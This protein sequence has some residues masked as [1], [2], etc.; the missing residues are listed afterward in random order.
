MRFE[1]ISIKNYRQYRELTIEFPAVKETDLH[2]LVA[3]NGIGKTNLLNAINWCLYGDEPHLGNKEGSLSIC[4][5]ASMRENREAGLSSTEV[6]VC[7]TAKTI[8]SMLKIERSI[9]VNSATGF[10]GRDALKI[11]E[12]NASGETNICEGDEAQELI[13]KLLPQKIRQYFFFDGEQLFNYFGKGS[14]TTHVKDSIH[15]IAQV[16]IVI[17]ARQHLDNIIAEYQQQVGR[18]NPQLDQLT[19]KKEELLTNKAHYESLIS[20]LEK[21]ITKSEEDI[22]EMS[23]RI[24]GTESVV[25]DNRI[26]EQNLSRLREIE[27]EKEEAKKTLR[28]LIK[29]YYVL[30]ALHD[31][32][33][34]TDAYITQKYQ[35]GSLPP[36]IDSS[37]IQ[38]SLEAHKCELCSAPLSS[39]SEAY[40]RSLLE[41][42]NISSVV[43]NK[44]MQIKNDVSRF[45]SGTNKYQEDLRATYTLI[46][47]LEDE[48]STLEAENAELY[49][50]ISAC[51]SSEQIAA[52]MEQ[53][54]TN[55]KLINENQRRQGSYE[56]HIRSICQEIENVEQ[57]ISSALSQLKQSASLKKE[58]SFA[59]EARGILSQI[60]Q[61]ITD[62]VRSKMETETMLQFSS[63]IWKKNTYGRIELTPNYQLK[64]YH[65]ITGESCLGS[66][67]AAERELLA[68]AFTIALHKVS[69]HDGLLFIDTPVGRVS[70]VNRE[71]FARSLIEVSKYKQLILAFTPS[72]FSEEISKYFN[73]SVVSSKNILVSSDEETTQPE[74]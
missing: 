22:S 32:N 19:R 63:L 45:L 3:S 2:V 62:D 5:L 50:R 29:K 49:Q 17:G 6:T 12:I 11:H 55:R 15:E 36:S 34:Q 48:Y 42:F 25:E 52:W 4:N 18:L 13:G 74:V 57:E 58:L 14:D 56:E 54:E 20:E 60:E 68:L 72:E 27:A 9:P 41:R 40:L 44:L 35:S 53:R 73:V 10:P 7:I 64:L 70:D 46:Q 51:S 21:S 61:E 26:Y 33:T 30:I 43:S 31:A 59:Q 65:K 37:L 38:H 23:Q 8:K 47:G 24:A 16:S 67:S 66:C 69:G 71:N 1:S 28:K 39:S